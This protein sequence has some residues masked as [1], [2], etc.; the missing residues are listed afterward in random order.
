VKNIII[1]LIVAFL[2]ALVSFVNIP[3]GDRLPEIFFGICGVLFS[4]GMSQAMNFDF[5]KIVDNEKYNKNVKGLKRVRMSFVIQF[6]IASLSFVALQILKSCSNDKILVPL[7]KRQFYA[8][9]FLDLVIVYSLFFFLY[10][11]C[12]LTNKKMELDKTYRDE[13]VEDLE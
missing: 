3:F 6:I 9:V 10:N 13:A 7:I 4:V 12:I 11:F 1:I 2:L 5:Y 8:N